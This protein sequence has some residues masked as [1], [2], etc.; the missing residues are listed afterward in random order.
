M[1]RIRCLLTL[2]MWVSLTAQAQMPRSEVE[3]IA[4]GAIESGRI[5]TLP[6]QVEGDIPDF[7]KVFVGT[8]Y[9]ESPW[10]P[11]GSRVMVLHVVSLSPQDAVTEGS[12]AK[13]F[14][15]IHGVTFH[16][17]VCTGVMHR[18]ASENQAVMKQPENS[19]SYPVVIMRDPATGHAIAYPLSSNPRYFQRLTHL[20]GES[21]EFSWVQGTMR[22][23]KPYTSSYFR[24]KQ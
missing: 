5:N 14:M 1:S 23:S 16:K 24:W 6:T 22:R 2:C 20:G 18:W 10:W 4:R 21:F 17:P 8:F 9:G 19:F 15:E 3:R 11:T 13:E 7:C 12:H